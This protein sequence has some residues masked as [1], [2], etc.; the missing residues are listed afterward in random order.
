VNLLSIAV[1]VGFCVVV[2]AA[3][4]WWFRD[5]QLLPGDDRQLI[6]AKSVA[7]NA[8]GRYEH[9]RARCV[10]LES[11]VAG[12]NRDLDGAKSQIQSLNA[13]NQDMADLLHE[14]TSVNS[15]DLHRSQAFLVARV[16]LLKAC[17]FGIS[18]IQARIFKYVGG[19]AY[20]KI[21]PIFDGDVSM[22]SKAHKDW[23]G[24]EVALCGCVEADW[25][26][27]QDI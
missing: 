14:Y 21:K 24:S 9:Y 12:L 25:K 3:L 26:A 8:Q 27:E 10:Y 2:G 16:Q 13:E 5:R 6:H 19:A 4:G 22:H 23:Q 1:I 17:G 15:C 20:Y 11:L 18:E 7:Y